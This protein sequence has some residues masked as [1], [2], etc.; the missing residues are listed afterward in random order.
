MLARLL[1]TDSRW[2]A[3]Y[4]FWR[5]FFSEF[6]GA[7]AERTGISRIEAFVD[8]IMPETGHVIELVPIERL[9]SYTRPRGFVVMAAD[10]EKEPPRFERVG[11]LASADGEFVLRLLFDR[12]GRVLRL[13]TLGGSASP[14]TVAVH[15]ESNRLHVLLDGN[16]CGM[17]ECDSAEVARG[18][19]GGGVQV[20]FTG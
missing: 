3:R 8:R 1:A 6:E 2:R 13:F 20:R 17:V 14:Q 11:V 18:L 15:F 5:D 10:S 19:A 16:G 4:E 12:V 9:P 7:L